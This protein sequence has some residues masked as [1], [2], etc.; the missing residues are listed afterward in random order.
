MTTVAERMESFKIDGDGVELDLIIWRR[1]K[2]PTPG[3]VERTYSLN[4]GLADL[5]LF[6]PHDTELW[7]PLDQPPSY[8][9]INLVRLW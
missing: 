2:R 5:G 7:I 1:Y 3:L 9:E 4:K 8:Q 6:L